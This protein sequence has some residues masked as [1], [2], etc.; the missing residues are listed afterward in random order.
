[1]R[2]RNSNGITQGQPFLVTVQKCEKCFQFVTRAM[3][4]LFNAWLVFTSS[5]LCSY[6]CNECR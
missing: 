1:M 5:S 6:Q 2:T 3:S 4:S